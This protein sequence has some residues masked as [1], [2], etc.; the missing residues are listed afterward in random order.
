MPART[1]VGGNFQLILGGVKSGF[2]KS[3]D[4]GGIVGEV[5][6]ENVGS[7]HFSKKHVGR[8]SYSPF[9]V[10]FGMSM[11]GDVYDWINASWTGRAIS[12]DGAIVVSDLNLNAVSQRE[13]SHAL[14]TETSIPAMDGAAKDAA[15]FT[16]TFAPEYTRT[17]KA[18]GKVSA[19]IK[20]DQKP[21]LLSNF[22]L[23]IDGLDCTRVSRVGSLTVRQPLAT[24]A[25][26]E[27][28]DFI[29]TAGRV[30]FPSLTVT[31]SEVSAQGWF[32]WFD[33]FVVKGNNDESREK[34][35]SLSL[36]SPNLAEELMR[37]DFFNL[38]IFSIGADKAEASSD[39]V[40]TVTA[41][42]YCE[43]MELRMGGAKPA[44][45]RKGRVKKVSGRRR[46]TS[47]RR[48]SRR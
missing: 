35:G 28:R 48:P 17:A 25:I 10:Q 29:K 47:S 26:G 19:A 3:V 44:I 45:A 40:A 1:Y 4:G 6:V 14:I 5:V 9:T 13:F 37:I 32:D 38:G 22:R 39:S 43:R 24:D 23:T 11:A 12:K 21:W 7:S 42:L 27:A 41:Q 20:T 16:V 36:L 31:M 46:S 34:S 8:V 33:D 18:S 2:L 30:E 15:Y